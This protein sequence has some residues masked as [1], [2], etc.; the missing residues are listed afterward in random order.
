MKNTFVAGIHAVGKSYLCTQAAS[1]GDW[2]HSSAS[3][4]IKQE[5]GSANWDSAKL[6][7]DPNINQ[8]ALIAAVS[9]I[10]GDGRKLLLDGHFVLRNAKD[11]FV[12]L[13]ADV[14]ADLNLDGVILVEAPASLVAERLQQRDGVIR[15][16]S[17]IQAFLD[18][19]RRQ[20]E[21]VCSALGLKLTILE[22][23][24]QIAFSS[25]IA[26]SGSQAAS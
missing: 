10:N 8:K 18:A 2:L 26:G 7:D 23:P 24:D 19:E 20:A 21:S 1:T 15:R 3:A 22:A 11:E 25:A 6:V 17:D 9:R 13:G 16:E 12:F 5:L 4:L 14:F